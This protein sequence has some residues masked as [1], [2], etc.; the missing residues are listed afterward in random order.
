MRLSASVRSTRN[1]W[2]AKNRTPAKRCFT[3]LT[4]TVDQFL[5]MIV[6]NTKRNAIA[7][8]APDRDTDDC[9]D[10]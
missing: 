5:V 7:V 10:R 3:P 8:P 1:F 6:R 4:S 2:G 9:R